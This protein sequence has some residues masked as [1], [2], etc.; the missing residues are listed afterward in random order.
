MGHLKTGVLTQFI[1]P[2]LRSS[3]CYIVIDWPGVLLLLVLFSP[4]GEA[5]VC[6]SSADW[7]HTLIDLYILSFTGD[8]VKLERFFFIVLLGCFCLFVFGFFSMGTF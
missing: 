7:V 6:M 3:Q 8:Y 5:F 1:A 4:S 2:I